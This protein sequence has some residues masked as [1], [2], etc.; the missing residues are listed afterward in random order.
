MVE[1]SKCR[2]DFEEMELLWIMVKGKMKLLCRKCKVLLAAVA[3]LMSCPVLGDGD[4]APE[5]VRIY[6]D[7]PVLK[8]AKPNAYFMLKVDGKPN[9]VYAIEYALD[10]NVWQ[11]LAYIETNSK[12]EWVSPLVTN[13]GDRAFFRVEVDEKGPE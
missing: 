6:I 11:L 1:C 9:T 10:L 4:D 5:A 8:L 12:G 13:R 3:I 2:K 7:F